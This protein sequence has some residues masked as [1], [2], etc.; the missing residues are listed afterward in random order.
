MDQNQ[1]TLP[2]LKY[3]KFS[4]K[5][6]S[7]ALFVHNSVYEKTHQMA[8]RSTVRIK[9]SCENC[10]CNRNRITMSLNFDIFRFFRPNLQKDPVKSLQ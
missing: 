6:R 10:Q 4:N 9:K 1:T 7:K 2:E 3:V 8:R 5:R